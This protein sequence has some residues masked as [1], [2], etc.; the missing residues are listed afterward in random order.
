LARL[1]DSTGLANGSKFS[2]FND[3]V[4]NG[5]GTVAFI[6]TER[7]GTKN[8]AALWISSGQAASRALTRIAAVGQTAP[9]TNGCVFASLSSVALPEWKNAGPLVVATL[10]TGPRR[11]KAS[12]NRGLWGVDFNGNLRL[13]LRTGSMLPGAAAGSPLVRTFTVLQAVAGSNG[14]SRACDSLR[15]VFCNVTF[16]NGVTAV[17]KIH[18]P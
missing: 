7:A 10:K 8:T 17:V 18:V 14:Q 15:D 12:N 16:S 5:A 6:A 3:P 4:S 11:A 13:L 9:E 1:G 2:N